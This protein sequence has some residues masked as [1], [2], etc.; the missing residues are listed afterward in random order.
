MHKAIGSAGRQA[1]ALAAGK[2]KA[3]RPEPK[4]ASQKSAAPADDLP[5]EAPDNQL[6][7]ETS[8]PGAMPEVQES[9]QAST[10]GSA[11]AQAEGGE[12]PAAPAA[13]VKTDE[14]PEAGH[15]SPEQIAERVYELFRRDLRVYRQ[16]KGI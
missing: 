14:A 11:S 7:R 13:P 9:E 8:G 1:Q 6:Q 10:S 2:L 12:N 3:Y 16:R 15:P 4:A 5:E